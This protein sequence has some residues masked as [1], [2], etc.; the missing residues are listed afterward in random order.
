MSDWS[1]IR[2]IWLIGALVLVAPAAR[3]MLRGGNSKLLHLVLW[4]GIVLALAAGYE[5]FQGERFDERPVP[6]PGAGA[7]T[8]AA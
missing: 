6:R 8:V 4:L 1:I 5:L 2:L 7:E 3:A